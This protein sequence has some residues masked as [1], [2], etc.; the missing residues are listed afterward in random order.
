[1]RVLVQLVQTCPRADLS[2]ELMCVQAHIEQLSPEEHEGVSV[3]RH[4]ATRHS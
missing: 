1:M 2:H 4:S 3:W